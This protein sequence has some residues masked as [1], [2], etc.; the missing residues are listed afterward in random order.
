MDGFL[1]RLGG[2][3]HGSHERGAAHCWLEWYSAG[4]LT[5]ED[6]AQDWPGF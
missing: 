6:E 5:G 3:Y 4:K 2:E 1:R